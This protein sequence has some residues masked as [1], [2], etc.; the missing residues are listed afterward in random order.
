MS[1]ASLPLAA[2]AGLAAWAAAATSAH[3]HGANPAVAW[4][5]DPEGVGTVVDDSFT[6]G[7]AD[8]DIPIP[9]GTATVDFFYTARRPPA[10][11]NGDIHPLLEGEVIVRGIL[12]KDHTNTYA[13]DTRQVPAGSYYLWSMVVEPPE[14]FMSPQIISF[15]PGIVTVA[16][17]GDPVHP[18]LIVTTPDTPFRYADT[19]FLV[20]WSAFDP[21]GAG[22]VKIE[23]GTSSMGLD[24]QTLV[25]DAPATDGQVQWD[26]SALPEGDWYLRGTL[27]DDRGLSFT[28][29]AQFLLLIAHDPPAPDAGGGSDAATPADAGEVADAGARVKGPK[30][31]CRCA[32]PEGPAG[33]LAGLVLLTT[34]A[35]RRRTR[36]RAPR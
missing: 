8:A 26:T 34:W 14:E 21:S 35:R 17:P 11:D 15:S 3:A 13:W 20:K 16:H 12:E 18:A 10:F 4:M 27:T 7:W 31:G 30:Q 9:T 33:P 2:L 23:V 28:S 1:R 32:E 24:Y 5:K 22:R 6:F 36:T 25:E 29:Y 19:A